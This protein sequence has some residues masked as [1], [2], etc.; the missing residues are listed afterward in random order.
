MDKSNIAYLIATTITYDDIGQ[1]VETSTEKMIYCNVRSVTRD[2][3]YQAGETGIRPRWSITCFAPDYNNEEYCKL[4]NK[5]YHIY[6]SYVKSN[7]EIELYLEDLVG[8][9]NG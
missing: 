9:T 6:R 1:I 5:K 7:E 8:V 2:E 4:E 3:F